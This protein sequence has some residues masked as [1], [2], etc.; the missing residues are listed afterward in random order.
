M[1]AIIYLYFATDGSCHW[2]SQPLWGAIIPLWEQLH[3]KTALHVQLIV[4][5]QGEAEED[6]LPHQI[7]TPTSSL[8]QLQKGRTAGTGVTLIWCE[9]W[10]QKWYRF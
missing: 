1:P 5:K 8:C 4:M 3:P 10:G 6:N 9:Q 2:R 7:L